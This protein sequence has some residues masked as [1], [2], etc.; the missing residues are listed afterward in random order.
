MTVDRDWLFR[1][2][3]A[4]LRA[5]ALPG[6]EALATQPDGMCKADE[7]ALDYDHFL[8]SV[9]G[10]FADEF[11]EAQAAALRRV[12]EAL[13][14]MSGPDNAELWTDAAVCSHP[15]WRHVRE[16]ARQ[17]MDLLGWTYD[18]D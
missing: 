9:L 7:L 6:Q 2:L 4:S 13:T 12:D 16:L 3:Q 18:A 1:G 11:T 15:R 17:A 5:L 14:E 8:I 10:N